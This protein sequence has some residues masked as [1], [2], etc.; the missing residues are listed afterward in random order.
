MVCWLWAQIRKIA[1]AGESWIVVSLVGA[2]VVIQSCVR[3]ADE[4]MGYGWV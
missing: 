2:L 1:A 4:A 3:E